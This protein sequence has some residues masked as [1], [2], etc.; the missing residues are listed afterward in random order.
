MHK[1][2]NDKVVLL[3]EVEDKLD[4]ASFFEKIEE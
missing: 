4:E 1:F 2:L 3:D